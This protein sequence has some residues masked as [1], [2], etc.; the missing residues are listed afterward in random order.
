MFILLHKI[1]LKFNLNDI[2][3]DGN[4]ISSLDY[5]RQRW[6]DN[7][8]FGT[9]FSLNYKKNKTL[10]IVASNKKVEELKNYTQ[11]ITCSPQIFSHELNN[12]T[13]A[14]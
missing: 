5:V 1:Y 13:H 4:T 14:I 12:M 11:D 2:I 6:L 8:F 3:I 9:T 10:K 7:D